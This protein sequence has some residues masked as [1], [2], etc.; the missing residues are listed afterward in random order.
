[1]M[2]RISLAIT[3]GVFTVLGLVSPASAAPDTD[4]VTSVTGGALTLK[5]TLVGTGS[6]GA[7]I[8]PYAAAIAALVVGWRFVRKF[9]RA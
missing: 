8:L 2:R 4:A 1:M 3:L 9:L 6:I 5:D 7:A